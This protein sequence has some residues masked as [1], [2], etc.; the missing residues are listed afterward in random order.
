MTSQQLEEV[1]L[2]F[3]LGMPIGEPQ[4]V[5]GGR[6]HRLWRVHTSTGTY[7]VKQLNP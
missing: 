7:A 2:R 4:S 5:T 3:R 1:C 6:L